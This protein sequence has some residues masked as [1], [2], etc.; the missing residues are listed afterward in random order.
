L[1]PSDSFQNDIPSTLTQ[2]PKHD[3]IWTVEAISSCACPLHGRGGPLSVPGWTKT[4]IAQGGH[5]DDTLV[6]EIQ[7]IALA[8][9]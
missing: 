2:P 5:Y 3:L 6:R 1:L 7:Y 4:V 9:E 8:R